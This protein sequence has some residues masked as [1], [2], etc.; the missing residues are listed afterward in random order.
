M[1]ALLSFWDLMNITYSTTVRVPFFAAIT[2]VDTPVLTL[3]DSK[4]KL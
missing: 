4:V 3:T 1:N 2:I